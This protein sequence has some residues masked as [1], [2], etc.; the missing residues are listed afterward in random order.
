M[1]DL[2]NPTGRVLDIITLLARHPGEDFSL[3]D[4]AQQTGI[5]KASAHRVLL[6]LADADFL[7]RH[8]RRKTYSLG[9]GLL[10]VGQAALERYPGLDIARSEMAQLSS[11]LNIQCSA[12]ALVGGDLLILARDGKP[13]S[14]E[15]LNRVGE[16]RPL[17]PPMGMC[18][19]AWGSDSVVEP[20]LAFAKQHM[21]AEVY[22]WLLQSLALIRRRGYALATWTWRKL[23]HASLLPAVRGREG[24]QWSTICELVGELNRDQVQ[25]GELKDS[26]FRHIGQIAAP[27]FAPDSSVAFQLVLSGLPNTLTQRKLDRCI[28][29]LLAS[30]AAVTH[31]INGS[32][33]AARAHQPG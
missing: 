16:R 4:I 26:D 25:L 19:V 6:T 31:R 14:H 24:A 10:A 22:A 28:E 2:S 23:G 9:M 13:Q 30:A 8:A 5:S 12:T 11:E 18:H 20:Y 1:S 7:A 17:I 32:V 29:K 15:S 3:A 33:P 27:V 21:Q